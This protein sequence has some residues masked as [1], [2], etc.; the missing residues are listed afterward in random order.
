MVIDMKVAYI[1]QYSIAPWE[2]GKAFVVSRLDFTYRQQ[3]RRTGYGFW[4]CAQKNV[5]RCP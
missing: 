4:Q 2:S 5:L 1:T 3:Y